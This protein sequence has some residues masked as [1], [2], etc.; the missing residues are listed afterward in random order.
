MALEDIKKTILE[1][2]G[3]RRNEFFNSEGEA[4]EQQLLRYITQATTRLLRAQSAVRLDAHERKMFIAEIAE[5][6]IGLGPIQHL[7]ND[8]EVAEI[9]VNGPHRVYV[10]RQGRLRATDVDFKDPRRLLYFIEKILAPINR[11]IDQTEPYVDARLHDGSRVNVIIS[12]LAVDGPILTIRKFRKKRFDLE[13]LVDLGTLTRPVADFLVKCIKQRLNILISGGA[14]AGKTTTLNVLANFIPADERIVTIED[15]IELNILNEH[16]IRLE[17]RA[18][19]IEGKGA[20]TIRDLLRNALHMRPDR[21]IV[22]ESRGG[23]VLDM[24]QAMNIGHDGSLTT[25]HANSTHDAVTRLETMALMAGVNITSTVVR[26]QIV[27]GVDLIVHLKRFPDGSRKIIGISEIAKDQGAE[28]LLI[29][30]LFV[31]K[32]SGESETGVVA[33]ESTSTGIEPSSFKLKTGI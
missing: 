3:Q 9:M 26:R 32:P 18:P 6:A 30:D 16:V 21:V 33:D 28:N 7:L 20:V 8:P 24:L 12:P 17:S 5:E 19:N 27:A 1:T 11:R 23:E 15:T 31:F 2:L 13:E 22:G 14:S 29:R 4:N 10:E 25:V